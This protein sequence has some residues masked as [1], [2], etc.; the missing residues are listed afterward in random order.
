LWA[1]SA[2]TGDKVA[3]NVQTVVYTVPE[4]LYWHVESKVRKVIRSENG[5]LSCKIHGVLEPLK[6][7]IISKGPAEHYYACKPLQ[8][9]L[10]STLKDMPCFRAIG[11]VLNVLDIG[12]VLSVEGCGDRVKN[13]SIDYSAATD[14]LSGTYSWKILADLVQNLPFELKNLYWRVL[15]NHKLEYPKGHEDLNV[16]M[17]NGQLMGSIL[18]FPILCLANLGVYLLVR[19][20]DPST[21]EFQVSRLKDERFLRWALDHVLINGDDMLYAADES[22]WDVQNLVSSAVGLEPSLGKA[23]IHSDACTI[24]SVAYQFDQTSKVPCPFRVDYL[25]VGLIENIRKV[26]GSTEDGK[27]EPDPCPSVLN[28]ILLSCSSVKKQHQV[29]KMYLRRYETGQGRLNLKGTN[30]FIHPS[31]GGHGVLV[32]LGWRW[33]VTEDQMYTANVLMGGR[34]AD[35]RPH[36]GRVVNLERKEIDFDDPFNVTNIV[37]GEREVKPLN[38]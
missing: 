11:R 31:F 8:K 6:V 30:L 38:S 24:N 34:V 26:Q 18:S 23:Y 1:A 21:D 19:C 32:P 2:V 16:G 7:R 27:A 3:F 36:F 12:E 9:L 10:W 29:L 15:G 14:G 35:V 33:T 28:R 20:Y 25:A 17:E 37:F 4:E 22:L 13:F 5:Q